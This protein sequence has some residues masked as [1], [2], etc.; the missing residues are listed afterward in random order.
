M[1]I[2]IKNVKQ[3]L[4]QVKNCIQ[5]LWNFKLRRWLIKSNYSL[6]CPT[7]WPKTC[8]NA[9]V[10]R[11]VLYHCHP[12]C[13]QVEFKAILIQE[14][15]CTFDPVAQNTASLPMT[16]PEQ[17]AAPELEQL[18]VVDA[19][20]TFPASVLNFGTCSALRLPKSTFVNIPDAES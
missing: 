10:L 7:V 18:F 15:L 2:I 3:L 9:I 16:L 6:W 12:K 19:N 8:G 13:F 5:T 11:N 20:R 4:I 1:L 14:A 17:R